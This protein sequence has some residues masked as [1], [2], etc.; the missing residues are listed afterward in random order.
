MNWVLYWY[1]I[2]FVKKLLVDHKSV[3]GWWA[4]GWMDGGKTWFEGLL[5]AVPVH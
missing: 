1:Q 4:D 3:F 5:T 2:F